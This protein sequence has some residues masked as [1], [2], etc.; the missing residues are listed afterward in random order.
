MAGNKNSGRK[1]IQNTTV[2]EICIKFGF[3]PI[4]ELIKL[5]KSKDISIE[6]QA[7][8]AND[9]LPY[10]Y[11]KLSSV[12]VSGPDGG[13][14]ELT[15]DAGPGVCAALDRIEAATKPESKK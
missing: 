15:V 1:N 8:I 11:P 10:I 5:R 4:E 6:L 7:K 2:R 13:P 3:D 9:L 12:Q 14:V